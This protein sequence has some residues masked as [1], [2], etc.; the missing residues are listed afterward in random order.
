[1]TLAGTRWMQPE[2][3]ALSSDTLLYAGIIFGGALAA[4]IGTCAIVAWREDASDDETH[5]QL[6]LGGGSL[7]EELRRHASGPRPDHTE[8]HV[9]NSRGDR[10]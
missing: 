6:G 4:F 1:M 2:M 7:A 5:R 3:A 10:L 9:H 8:S